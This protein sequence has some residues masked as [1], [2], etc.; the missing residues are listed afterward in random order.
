MKPELIK[1]CGLSTRD[2]IDAT[3]EG[4]A[5]H[6]GLI[7]FEKSPRHVTTDHARTLS[8]HAG[9]RICKVAVTVS[10]SDD[11]LQQIIEKVKPDLLQLHGSESVSRVTEL[12]TRF[13]LPVIKSLAINS[14]NDLEKA[15]EYIGVSDHLLFDAKAPEGVEVPGGN[16]IAF[17][18]EIMDHWPSNVPYILSGGLNQDNI[19][20]AVKNSGAAGVDISSGVETSP[21]IKSVDRIRE[22]LRVVVNEEEC[23]E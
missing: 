16:G 17:D 23:V 10:A 21:G 13:G 6:M 15:R 8:Q 14:V 3:I 7:F 20:E 11:Y 19:L 18:W 1:I 9:E 2:A 5:T 22:F 12:K 4:G